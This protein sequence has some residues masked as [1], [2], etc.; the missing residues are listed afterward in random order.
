MSQ[1]RLAL[2]AALLAGG[3][4]RALAAPDCSADALNALHVADVT[5]TEA[6]PVAASGTTPAFC[7]VKC[8]V[9]TRGEG[10]P[11]GSARFAM[12]FPDAWTQ[13]FFFMGVG[14]N[15]G[16]L[17]PAVNAVDRA[18]TLDK[19]YVTAVTDT[20]HTGNGTDASW[21]RGPDGKLDAAKVADFFHRAAHD[22]TL[23][24]KQFSQAFYGAPV[25]RAY[26]DGCSTGGRMAMMEAERYPTD[27]DGIIAGDP[28]MDYNAG[29]L[30]VVV[31]KAAFASPEAYLSPASLAAIDKAVTAR[32]DRLDGAP[33][34]LVQDPAR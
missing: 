31:Q 32:C 17:N 9:V 14:G 30:R 25:K 16:T 22:V 4:A 34:G 15:A 26:F 13:R 21:V 7:D 28:N 18:S 19:G 12:Q 11:D 23:A 6:A 27:F 1:I 33:D 10:A 20:G 3:A 29:L 24:G 8:T 5:V 2:T